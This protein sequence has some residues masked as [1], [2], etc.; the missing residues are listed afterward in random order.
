M[1]SYSETHDI[2]PKLHAILAA[3]PDAAAEHHLGRP[4]LTAY[5]IAIAFAQRHPDDVANLG[6][7]IGG[8][9]SG[10]RYSLS[11]YVARLLSGYVKANPNGPIEGAFISNWHLNELTFNYN[12]QLIRSS[13]T[14][15]SFTLS[16]FR[17]KS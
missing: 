17:L 16:M 7:P 14:E 5:Q 6:H 2:I 1:M 9:G 12:E 8:Q 15:S 13:L 3:V 11:T 10:S 4:F